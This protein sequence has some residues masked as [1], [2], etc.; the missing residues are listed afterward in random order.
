MSKRKFIKSNLT[1]IN[2]FFRKREVV[3]SIRNAEQENKGIVNI[4][5]IDPTNVGDF[6]CAPHL[7]FDELGHDKIDILDYKQSDKKVTDHWIK[8]VSQN[9]LLIGGGGLLNRKSFEKQLKLFEYLHE[10]GK[11]T[12][13]WG[14]GHNSANRKDFGKRI[15]YNIDLKKYGLVGIRDYRA[16]VNWVPC[17]SCMH[18][19]FDK[20]YSEK[21]EIGIIYHK[22]SIK[23]KPLLKRLDHFPSTSNTTDLDDLVSFIGRSN[24]IVTD[25]YHAMYWSMLLEKKVLVIPNSTKFYNF[26]YQPVFTTF[27]N[28]ENDMKKAKTY[29]GILQ[30]CREINV[31]FAKKVLNYLND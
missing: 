5:R 17:V 31:N 14:A 30:E 21:Q 22:D 6:Y 15:E 3:N 2:R 7:Y 4:Y 10:K 23:N 11:K 12:V 20:A 28:F 27:E 18:E 1:S 24:T 16:D 26:K 13:I 19:I 25:S 9:A 8:E 29:S